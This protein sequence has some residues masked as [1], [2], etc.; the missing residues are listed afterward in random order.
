MKTLPEQIQELEA[1]MGNLTA[2]LTTANEAKVAALSARDEAVTA[3]SVAEGER[4]AARNE[5]VTVRAEVVT[6]KGERDALSTEN[7]KLKA[8]AKTA[9]Q[10]ATA[11]MAKV[12]QPAPLSADPTGGDAPGT[13]GTKPTAATGLNRVADFFAKKRAGN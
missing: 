12:G 7:A 6:V 8:E 9:D 10:L 4:D 2:E 13:Q 5:V 11:I 3:K 1:K